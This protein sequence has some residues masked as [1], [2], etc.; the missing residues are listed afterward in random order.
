MRKTVTALVLL[1]LFAALLVYQ[2]RSQHVVQH[3]FETAFATVEEVSDSILASGNM[4]FDSQLELRSELIGVVSKVAVKQGDQVKR[5]ELLLEL[6][7]TVFIAQFEQASSAI[8]IQKANIERLGVLLANDK[9][10]LAQY[11]RLFDKNMLDRDTLADAESLVKSRSLELEGA[12]YRLKQLQAELTQAKN[13]LAKTEFR[14]PEDALVIAVG[15]KAGETV[16]PS[17]ASIAGSSLVTLAKVDSYLAR[18]RVDE[19]DLADV[20]IG[21]SVKVYLAADSSMPIAG[22]VSHIGLLA[23]TGRQGNGVYFPVD[24]RLS[25]ASP[26]YPGMSC[27][28]EIILT[29]NEKAVSV[30]IAAVKQEGDAYYVWTVKERKAKRQKV[31]LGI[32]SD[33]RQQI[34]QGIEKDDIVIIGPGRDMAMLENDMLIAVR[35]TQ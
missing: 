4:R 25:A 8:A 31:S 17:A 28:S 7:K 6:D 27:R 24:V 21:Q 33:V 1:M 18:L 26:L 13:N 3:T 14:A 9:R 19:A 30:P 2:K 22:K 32:A 15:V 10:K 35:D 34:T 29:A 16:I 5:G 12:S 20:F 23:Q 11:Q